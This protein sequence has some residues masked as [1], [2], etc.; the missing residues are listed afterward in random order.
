MYWRLKSI[1]ELRD[2]PASERL[3]LWRMATNT[4][5]RLADSLWLALVF[6]ATVAPGWLLFH[7]TVL[8]HAFWVGAIEFSFILFIWNRLIFMIFAFHHRPALRRLRENY[9]PLPATN[10]WAVKPREIAAI[11]IG[12]WIVAMFAVLGAVN[13]N[14]GRPQGAYWVSAFCFAG[15]LCL[16]IAWYLTRQRERRQDRLARGLC[17]YCGYDL[18]ATPDRCPECGNARREGFFLP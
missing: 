17:V 5:L 9:S 2:L 7:L 18:R 1:P 3:R 11:G 16:G 12:C 10:P 6:C 14:A 15:A 13:T 8:H 4:R